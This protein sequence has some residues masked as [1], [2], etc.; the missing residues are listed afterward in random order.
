MDLYSVLNELSYIP[1]TMK[2]QGNP[3]IDC[4]DAITI[5]KARVLQYASY[6]AIISLHR[7]QERTT[8]PLVNPMWRKNLLQ[9]VHSLLTRKKARL[10]LGRLE[11]G[12]FQSIKRKYNKR[13]QSNSEEVKIQASRIKLEGIITANGNF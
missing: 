12:F 5:Y 4:G 3:A 8:K 10:I 1:F 9:E 13:N 11:G 7:W 6:K 2:W